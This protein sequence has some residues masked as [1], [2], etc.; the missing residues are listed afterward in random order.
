MDDSQS[1]GGGDRQDEITGRRWSASWS[2][3]CG[4]SS[5]SLARFLGTLLVP[6][7]V[8]VVV[9]RQWDRIE[10]GFQ[11]YRLWR[12]QGQPRKAAGAGSKMLLAA[13][14]RCVIETEGATGFWGELWGLSYKS[15]HSGLLLGPLLV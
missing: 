2:G 12:L 4:A 3:V 11:R 15:V 1:A 9:G 10:P 13:E 7:P 8:A 14:T 5:R 6:D